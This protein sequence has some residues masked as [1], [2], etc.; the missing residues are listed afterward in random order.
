MPSS[1]AGGHRGGGAGGGAAAGALDSH[2]AYSVSEYHNLCVPAVDRERAAAV[3]AAMMR[4]GAA[5][6]GGATSTSGSRSSTLSNLI[7]GDPICRDR[8]WQR[9][10]NIEKQ[11]ARDWFA[12]FHADFCSLSRTFSL[13]VCHLFVAIGTHCYSGAAVNLC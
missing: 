10:I 5:G 2:R 8:F 12:S 1:N 3:A 11:A 7:H 13:S 6:T 9:A 4:R